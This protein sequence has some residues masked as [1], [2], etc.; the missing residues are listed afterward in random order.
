MSRVLVPHP[1]SSLFCPSILVELVHSYTMP[2]HR[3]PLSRDL[4]DIIVYMRVSAGTPVKEISWLTGIA[5][6]T[7]YQILQTWKE[8]GVSFR[9]KLVNQGRPRA[10]NYGDT[11]VC[12]PQLLS[13]RLFFTSGSSYVVCF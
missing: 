5:R 6:G 9:E 2:R 3:T 11:E 7:I 13:G 4:R 8:T 1:R 10:L 12:H